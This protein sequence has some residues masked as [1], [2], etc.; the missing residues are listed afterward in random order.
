MSEDDR[1]R[2]TDF[3]TYCE[4]CTHKN[5]NEA[6]SPCNECLDEGTREETVKPLYFEQ[7]KNETRR[8][9]T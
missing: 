5:L 8:R 2:I 3:Q 1:C 4:Q 9:K 6:L 7:V